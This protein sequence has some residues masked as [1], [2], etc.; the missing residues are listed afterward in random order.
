[1]PLVDPEI[2]A[3]EGGYPW[4]SDQSMTSNIIPRLSISADFANS[5]SVFGRSLCSCYL[6]VCCLDR[7]AHAGGKGLTWMDPTGFRLR[8][9]LGMI[10]AAALTAAALRHFVHV[11]G[12]F[13]REEI[14]TYALVATVLVVLVIIFFRRGRPP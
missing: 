7:L 2:I 10:A 9:V 8:H 5:G 13:S 6:F 12:G 1:M 11:D 14:R 3:L 4:S